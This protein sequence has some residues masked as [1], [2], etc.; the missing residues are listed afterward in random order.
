MREAIPIA[1][2]LSAQDQEERTREFRTI[3]AK[4][5]GRESTAEGVRLRFRSE[6][7]FA[8]QLGDLTRR[9]KECCPFFDFRIST[10]DDE[11][12]LDVGAPAD[13]RQIVERLFPVTA[14]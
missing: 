4:V 7:G 3:S 5:T 1:C 12:V 13:A 6:P 10:V 2:S 14:S 8:D 9:E 11:V